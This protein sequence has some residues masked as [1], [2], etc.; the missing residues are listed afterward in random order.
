MKSFTRW[1][2]VTTLLVATALTTTLALTA[3]PAE[4]GNI[5]LRAA[6]SEDPAANAAVRTVNSGTNHRYITVNYPTGATETCTLYHFGLFTDYTP[7]A[8][9]TGQMWWM[10]S[11]TS[12]T[13][14][15][16]RMDIQCVTPTGAGE[17]Y[18]TV[19]WQTGTAFTWTPINE[20]GKITAVTIP[21]NA[22]NEAATGGAGCS[23]STPVMMRIC[24]TANDGG[25]PNGSTA[26]LIM[27]RL[28]Y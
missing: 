24:R 14:V 11:G 8:D 19:G 10:T 1:L 18:D 5:I 2:L 25:S 4:A 12:T 22:M 26:Q 3:A 7:D 27:T 15:Q 17:N 16:L 6:G 23:A 9:I 21:S 13:A 28:T 20:A